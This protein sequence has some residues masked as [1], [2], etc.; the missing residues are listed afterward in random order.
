MRIKNFRRG[1]L[2]GT[3]AM[4]GGLMGYGRAAYAACAVTT[5]PSY[6]CTGSNTATQSITTSGAQVTTDPTFS[7]DTRPPGSGGD[8]VDVNADGDI[9]FTDANGALITGADTG[10]Y[11]N[12]TGS[13]SVTA[14]VNGSVSGF[15]DNGIQAD[16]NAGGTSLSVTARAGSSIYGYENG[17]SADNGGT[18]AL[19]ITADGSVTGQYGEGILARSED[20]S[21]ALTVTT[22]SN[23]SVTGEYFGLHAVNYGHGS[24]TVTVDGTVHADVYSGVQVDGFSY[25]DVKVTQGATSHISGNYGVVVNSGG[26]GTVTITADGTITADYSAITVNSSTAG[27]I[28]VTTG[29]DSSITGGRFGILGVQYGDGDLTITADGTVTSTDDRG[30]LARANG[31]GTTDITVKGKIYSYAQGVVVVGQPAGT[32]DLTITTKAGSSIAAGGDGIDAFQRGTGAV[33]ISVDGDVTGAGLIGSGVYAYSQD[34]SKGITITTGAG[35]KVSGSYYG[36]YAASGIATNHGDP[37]GGTGPVSITANGE[38]VSTYSSAI[39]ARSGGG[40][41]D[42]TVNG[43]VHAIPNTLSPPS[44]YAMLGVFAEGGDTTLVNNGRIDGEVSLAAPT[45]SFTNRG[46]WHSIGDSQFSGG[47]DTLVND[48]LII[49]AGSAGEQDVTTFDGLERLRNAGTVSLVDSPTNG[50]SHASD[51][52]TLTGDYEGDGG[53]LAL[54]VSLSAKTPAADSLQIDGNSTGTTYIVLNQTQS[55]AD[56]SDPGKLVLVSVAGTSDASNFVLK[57]GPLKAGLYTYDLVYDVTGAGADFLL[58]ASADQN[59]MQLPQAVTGAQN[60]FLDTAQ[61][62]VERQNQ[63]RDWQH[64]RAADAPDM[65]GLWLTVRGSQ[66]SND[67]TGHVAGSGLGKGFDTSFDQ[68]IAQIAGGADFGARL[69]GGTLLFGAVADYFASNQDLQAST[70]INYQGGSIGGYATFLRGGFFADTLAKADFFV[71]NY[72]ST[73][74][75]ASPQGRSYGLR[76]DVGYRFDSGAAYAEPVVSLAA[77]WTTVDDFGLYDSTVKPGTNSFTQLGAGLRA[78]W[79]D[80]ALDL[81]LTGRVWDGLGGDTTVGLTLPGSGVSSISD[82]GLTGVFGEVAAQL[83]YSVT[84]TAEVHLAARYLFGADQTSLSGAVGIGINW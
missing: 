30:I 27:N 32:G 82:A 42:I 76:S 78:G 4:A 7:V 51:T 13:G 5:S 48:G 58:E 35:S 23:S 17:I 29:H 11:M 25:S 22:G 57:D 49:A 24:T 43:F 38:V 71:E 67:S 12:G 21:G 3:A 16:N 73:G 34:S 59:A 65:S 19:S 52:L 84:D 20:G 39:V 10:L 26:T 60:I 66:V 69:A 28:T 44:P 2:W 9:S 70:S 75:S 40:A 63:L 36:I 31:S 61:S 80:E 18:G 53:T 1:L 77:A 45:T 46:T 14:D 55:A 56:T 54:D 50:G 62:W 74:D 15:K 41:I 8:G 68:S 37:T 79:K 81:M 6:L 33:T 47:D 64:A 83:G 72:D